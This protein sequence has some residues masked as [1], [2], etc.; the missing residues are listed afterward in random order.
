[1]RLQVVESANTSDWDAA[2]RA[3]GGTIFHSSTWAAYTTFSR[4]DIVPQFMT[5]LSDTG[6]A[7]GVALGFRERSRHILFSRMS[8]RLWLDALPA[9]YQDDED[10]LGEYLRLL[11]SY[12]KDSGDIELRVGSFASRVSGRQLERQNFEVTRRL[13]FEL[14][15]EASEDDLWRG[16]EY[17]RR[18]NIK[19]A[20]RLGVKL[21]ELP[22]PAGVA[23]LRRLQRQSGERIV[24]RG[25]PDG[26]YPGDNG[27]DPAMLLVDSGMGRIMGADLDGELVSA[28]LFTCFNGLV[29]HTLSG[30]SDTA[31]E[32]QAPTLLLWE[33]IKR[34]RAEGA[35]TFNFGGCS[36]DALNEHSPEHGVY[37]YKKAFGA[38]TRQCTSGQ[39]IVRK[40]AYSIASG[41][42]S[43][44]SAVSS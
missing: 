8:Q 26:S 31:L 41:L 21:A 5:L 16:F 7:H 22:G 12:A 39:K 40:M 44:Y 6:Q 32:T 34:Y 43:A 19:K 24:E 29:Y 33:T 10:L 3:V 35:V 28:G 17:K 37:V 36:I 42:K 18:K 30:H 11:E 9:V 23:A 27:M 4:P 25:G 38:T 20:Q 15:L 14:G 13:E 1:M 2:V